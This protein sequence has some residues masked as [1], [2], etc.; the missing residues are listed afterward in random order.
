MFKKNQTH[1]NHNN[2]ASGV[3]TGLFIGSMFG[4]L[5]GAITMLLLTPQSGKRT[6][7]QIQQKGIELRDRATEKI[8]DALMQAR[9]ESKKL[10][11]NGRHKAKAIL[12]QGQE[13]VAEQLAH[14]SEVVQTGKKSLLHS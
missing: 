13:L 2:T 11:K 3:A 8:E 7:A 9:L 4:S 1:P 10:A 6:R 5:I 14:V 12:H